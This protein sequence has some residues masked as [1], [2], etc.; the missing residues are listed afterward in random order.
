MDH[1]TSAMAWLGIWAAVA[2]VLL[3]VNIQNL[4]ITFMYFSLT[5]Q[6]DKLLVEDPSNIKSKIN[7][8]KENHQTAKIGYQ[9]LYSAVLPYGIIAGVLWSC[10]LVGYAV[11]AHFSITFRVVC[12]GFT[13][14]AIVTS[15]NFLRSKQ[16]FEIMIHSLDLLRAH[17]QT[18]LDRLQ[19]LLNQALIFP[20]TQVD[21]G[22]PIGDFEQLV[23][24]FAISELN[25]TISQ[26]VNQIQSIDKHIY[27]L[28]NRRIKL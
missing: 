11:D 12:G 17:R 20:Q 24:N 1:I 3:K 15:Y 13:G 5:K 2:W 10:L 23:L 27:T 21:V 25:T 4:T 26:A 6:L 8:F 18:E 19:M 9:Q 28:S 22:Q 7:K 16:A 14:I